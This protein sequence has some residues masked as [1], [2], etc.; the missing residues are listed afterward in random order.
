[1]L[2]R[3][4][5]LLKRL[6]SFAKNPKTDRYKIN[7]LSRFPQELVYTIISFFLAYFFI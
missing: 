5:V 4:S 6:L 1:M 7:L 2:Q 3:N